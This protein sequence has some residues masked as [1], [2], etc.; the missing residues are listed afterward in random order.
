MDVLEG[1]NLSTEANIVSM[2]PVAVNPGLGP[3]EEP[4]GL[5]LEPLKPILRSLAQ[6]DSEGFPAEGL[7]EYPMF[8]FII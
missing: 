3:L 8:Y 1:N 2:V 6:E 7:P 5:L 4:L